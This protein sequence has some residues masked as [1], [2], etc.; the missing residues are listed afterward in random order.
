MKGP[1]T[2]R[3]FIIGAVA[4]AAVAFLSSQVQASIKQ[5]INKGEFLD[6]PIVTGNSEY[7]SPVFNSDFK[8][9]IV[10]LAWQGSEEDAFSVR[11]NDSTGWSKW[12]KIGDSIQ[13]NEWRFITEPIIADGGTKLQYKVKSQDINKVK[14]IYLGESRNFLFDEWNPIRLFKKV[15]A[16]SDSDIVT[17]FEWEADEDWRFNAKEEEIWFT[18]YQT[19]EKFV[20]HHTAGSDGG[21]DPE[22]TIRG[23]YY[24]HSVVLGWGDIGYNYLI[25]QDG[26]I[27]EGRFGGD[28]AIGA[29]VYRNKA[30][31]IS[32]FGGEEFEA[33]FNKG[34]IGIAIL[35]DFEDMGLNSAVANAL[36]T[37][38]ANKAQEFTIEPGGESF[39]VDETYPNVVGHKDLDCTACPGANLYEELDSIRSE[40][41]G[42]YEELG[43]SVEPVVKASFVRQSAQSISINAGQEEEVWVEFKNTGN[44]AWRTYG[45]YLPHIV[46]SDGSSI[47]QASNWESQTYVTTADVSNI[48][49]GETGRFTF[50]IKSPIDQLEVSEEFELAIDNVVIEETSFALNLEIAG[51]SYA[52]KLASDV[53]APAMF[54]ADQ[55]TATFKFRNLGVSTWEK[56]E[57]YLNIYDLGD[58]VSRLYH[59]N[60]PEQN[61]KIDF[62]ESSV[63]PGE[64][65]TF[66]FELSAPLELGL[67]KNIYRVMGPEDIIQRESFS[68]TRIDSQY[69]AELIAHDVPLAA[70]NHWRVPIEVKFKNTGIGSWNKNMVLQVFDLGGD[71]SVFY[72]STWDNYYGNIMFNE[73]EVQ[74]GKIATFEFYL[75]SPKR[76]GLYLNTM[77]LGIDGKDIIVQG[78]EFTQITRI[79]SK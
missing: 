63:E 68:V 9:K 12:H 38:I 17:R 25:D 8:F 51:L 59:Q 40:S 47:L 54:A 76:T 64:T 49:P 28:G 57:V 44:V 4:L 55:Q 70:L 61:G 75:K 6:I 27:Y 69:T 41:Q 58:E 74:P 37:L 35:G 18:E 30:C 50:S 29:H 2:T 1:R 23:I 73:D 34:T 77:K 20:V 5:E 3:V 26:T 22:G 33:D 45:Q 7:V 56:E 31:A 14:L 43:G 15:S 16:Q 53:I 67:F 46:P 24:W 39:L 11:I 71:T 48:A 10:G 65:A 66:I 78:G 79:D 42:L 19:P 36:V 32:R 21:S 52:A 60:W 72:D 62:T 13:K